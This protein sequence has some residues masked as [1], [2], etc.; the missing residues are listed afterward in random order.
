MVDQ[1]LLCY[2]H[3][4]LR[5]IKQTRDYSAFGN[6]S[7]I[8]VGDFYQLP[9]VKGKSLYQS[10]VQCD[11]WNDNFLK[12][13]LIEIMRQKEDVK[14]AEVLNR[15]RVR[16][17]Q[18]KLMQDDMTM[19]QSRETGEDWSDALHIYP[20]NKQ[21]DEYNL[22]TL[23]A[24]CVDCVCILAR[25]LKKDERSGNMKRAEIKGKKSSL[26][27][28]LWLGIGARVMLMRNIDTSDG[29]VNGAVGTVHQIITLA[30]QSSP[31]RIEI[32]FDNK[33]IGSKLK[34]QSTNN[35]DVQVVPVEMVEECVTN[36]Y[37]RHQFPLKLAWACTVHKVQG[38]STDRAV[39]SLDRIFAAG[40][41]YVALSRVTSLN[42]LV[43]EG[44]NE[45]YIYCNGEVT[46]ALSK[47]A[48]FIEENND[49]SNNDLAEDDSDSTTII[50][51]NIQGL[52]VHE[53]DFT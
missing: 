18:G 20:C 27:K 24:K 37:V 8:A 3:G 30:A 1:K 43:I 29:L 9:P 26:S 21:V 33:S 53:M 52:Q 49:K 6:V 25:D 13:E 28:S 42:G 7:I 48:S 16:K 15:L 34:S 31:S 10:T 44:F 50:M 4:R 19:L 2:I 17:K 23:F 14:F 46:D 32:D 40:Q 22:K 35:P 38:L 47:M 5:Q 11:L 12:V 51:H 36:Q 45:K 39:I 41:A